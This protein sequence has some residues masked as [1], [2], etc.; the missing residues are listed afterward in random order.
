MDCED[1]QASL[2]AKSSLRHPVL[3]TAESGGLLC[4]EKPLLSCFLLNFETAGFLVDDDR[5]T[6]RRLVASGGSTRTLPHCLPTISESLLT[7]RLVSQQL[8]YIVFVASES[9]SQERERHFEESAP[10]S[11]VA[12]VAIDF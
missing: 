8:V 4:L 6:N 3:A 7:D 11:R 1:N 10:K 2:I 12:L 5:L 9:R